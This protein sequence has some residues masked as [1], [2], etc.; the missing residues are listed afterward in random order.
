MRNALLA[1]I[2]T[3]LL[4]MVALIFTHPAAMLSPGALQPAHA[5]LSMDCF[6]CHVPWRGAPAAQCMT[7]H[8]PADIGVRDTHG[9]ALR[10]PLRPG[11]HQKL[12]AGQCLNCHTDHRGA[13]PP[14]SFSHALLPPATQRQ[15]GSCHTAPATMVHERAGPVCSTCHT[16]KAWKPAAFDHARFFALTGPHNV[17]C[18]T[19]HIG[20]SFATY[21][22]YGCH[23]HRP[24]QIRAEH[25]EV[26]TRNLDNCVQCHRSADDEGDER[27]EGH[28][29]DD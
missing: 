5:K 12:P 21:T 14:L 8:K 4:V 23:E 2:V 22:C 7:C 3:L 26:A 10:Q 19:C 11:F 28:G 9:A 1:L 27:G 24:A 15:C 17:P 18:A 25:R 16:T 13:Q 29:D 20:K 6:A